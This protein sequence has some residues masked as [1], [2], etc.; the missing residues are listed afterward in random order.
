MQI[1]SNEIRQKFL[2]FMETKGHKIIPSASLVPEND[3]TVLFNTAWMQ[4]LVPYLMWE[5]HPLGKR[6]ANSQKC[7]RTN[8]IEEVW[9]DSHLTFFEMLWNWSLGDYFKEES[10][11]YSWE[12]LTSKDWLWLDPKMLAV[13]VFEWDEDAPRDEESALI[14]KKIWVPEN[15]ISYL[16]KSE[17]W[18]AAWDTGPCWWDT[19]I[20][21]WVWEWEPNP[22]SNAWNDEKNWMEIWNNVFMQYN[23]KAD[24][25][26][27]ELPNKNV[28]T[29]MWIERITATLN[30]AKTVYHTDIFKDIIAKIVEVLGI[31]RSPEKRN[32]IRIIADHSRAMTFLMSD[33]VFPSN[34]DQGYILRRLM[35][36]AI[37]EAYKLR[38]KGN[39]L[40]EIAKVVIKN[41]SHQ[42]PN[43]EENKETILT[44]IEKEENQ[45]GQTL[46]KWLKEFDK[47]VN[48]L[49]EGG[50]GGFKNY[51]KVP[52]RS[53][54]KQ[55]ARELRKNMTW[56]EKNIWYKILQKDSFNWY[57]FL[58]QKPLLDYI[59][60]FYCPELW[61]VIEIDWDSHDITKEYDNKRTQD[62]WKYKIKVI[63]FTNDESTK[64]I[65]WVYQKLLEKVEKLEENP[66]SLRDSSFKK[67]LKSPCSN[68]HPPSW[69]GL[70]KSS[71]TSWQLLQKGALIPWAK[72][73][74][75]YDTYGFPLEM[76]MELAKEH[77]LKVD[78]K[79]FEKAF[80]EHQEKSRNASAWK[81][82]G[83]LAD[84]SEAT[85]QLHTATHLLLAWLNEVLGWWIHQKGSNI[86]PERLRF[87]FNFDRKVEREELDKVEDFVNE[88]IASKLQVS[89]EEMEKEK[90]KESW[91]E[92]SF[93]EKYPDIVKVYK[94]VW[95][96]WK[97]YSRE[98]CWGPHV[99]NSEKMWK[100]KI[101]KEQA[102]SAWVRRI[103]AILVKE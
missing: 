74:K 71:V 70:G 68:G 67:E 75:L 28:D 73:F 52:Y 44:E 40:G 89:I 14:W 102:S 94:M 47:L 22:E 46:E 32:S 2:D 64:N 101:K 77:N 99:E 50:Q 5:K 4:P 60:D 15:R 34:T 27:E 18:W 49:L 26:L 35:R 98:L 79:W 9:D 72:A 92:G 8:D 84:D 13:T 39:F 58:R 25:T 38:F 29:G 91:V 69:R 31:E 78:K 62:L 83:G 76:T 81:F 100:F 6:L 45:F 54:L 21:Y 42:Y 41:L 51:V 3:P 17:N 82:K 63:R 96:N 16:P 24:G 93:W 103:K 33:W 55:K 11:A 19:E 59:V 97:V 90:A 43:L 65:E 86:T 53:D 1:T 30:G 56:P 48:P 66:Q 10:I 12:F 80:T 57:H 85:T 61:L 88:A 7:I 87:D 23:R 37:R 36:R 95:E 20:F